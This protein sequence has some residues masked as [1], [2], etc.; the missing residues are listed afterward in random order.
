VPGGESEV[1]LCQGIAWR[2]QAQFGNSEKT[3]KQALS[4]VQNHGLKLRLGEVLHQLGR[5]LL[6]AGRNEEARTRL[7]EAVEEADKIG[8]PRAVEYVEF[9]RNATS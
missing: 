1:L 7:T 8:I 3:L 6:L 9:L 2:E 5:T 4:V